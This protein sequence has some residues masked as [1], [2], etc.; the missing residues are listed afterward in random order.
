MID[1][2]GLRFGFGTVVTV[3]GD[4]P[5][6]Y[7]DFRIDGI[8]RYEC[9]G[10]VWYEV[11]GKH[12]GKQMWLECFETEEGL[13]FLLDGGESIELE[14]FGLD[15]DQLIDFD[16]RQDQSAFFTAAGKNWHYLESVEMGIV[17]VNDRDEPQDDIEGF[18]GWSF[19]AAAEMSGFGDDAIDDDIIL[20]IEK[21]RR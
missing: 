7:L 1:Y 10:E 5:G 15:E 19:I 17:A 14:T 20:S 3:S 16:A 9:D 12:R 6:D 11:T 8:D 2:A 18:Y 4:A 13:Q 21:I